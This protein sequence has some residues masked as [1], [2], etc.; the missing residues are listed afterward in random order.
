VPD[1]PVVAT[2]SSQLICQ[3]SSSGIDL[4][5]RTQSELKQGSVLLDI[6]A[7]E[8]NQLHR[9]LQE[10]FQQELDGPIETASFI[11][12]NVLGRESTVR[13]YELAIDPR[14]RR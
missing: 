9:P 4:Y 7:R 6:D 10:D 11:T 13:F 12:R 8:R 3:H 1:Q 5:G 14:T 2:P